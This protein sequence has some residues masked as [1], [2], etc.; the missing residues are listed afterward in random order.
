M[1]SVRSKEKVK[2]IKFVKPM[3]A[4]LTDAPFDDPSWIFEIKWDGYRAIAEV[5]KN[6]IELYSRNGLS[7]KQL[8]PPIVEALK[9]IKS[10][11]VLDGEIVVFNEHDK[12]DFQKLQQ[13]GELKKGSLVYY[14]FDCLTANG[15][16]LLT[17]PLIERKEILKKLIPQNDT[18]RYADHIF[19]NGIECFTSARKMDLEG[20]IAKRA[21][22]VYHVGKRS[23]DWLKIKNHNVQEAIIVGYTQ[24]KGSRSN[25]GALILA[26]MEHGTL[27]YIGHT[28]TGFTN[29][30]LHDLHKK[31]KPLERLTSPF[32]GK[33]PVHSS[34]TWLEPELVCNIKFTEITQGG[35]LRHPVFMGLRIDK[36]AE[37]VNRLEITPSKKAVNKKKIPAKTKIKK[38]KV[39]S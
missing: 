35:I 27:K 10:E 14:V 24:P 15:K 9:K 20:I 18:I 23:P 6:N 12:P 28:G 29:Q 8:Y 16:S 5:T 36:G 33:V 38:K 37:E 3:L 11:V 1:K 22:S 31:M 32:A 30:T 13:F 25:F 19:E 21:S 7:F 39:V 4:T 17:L 34:V 2:L 26:I